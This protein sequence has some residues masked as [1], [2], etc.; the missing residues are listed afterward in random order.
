VDIVQLDNHSALL[1]TR[2]AGARRSA[3]IAGALFLLAVLVSV[4]GSL[5]KEDPGRSLVFPWVVT[6]ALGLGYL[7]AW[8]RLQIASASAELVEAL[9]RSASR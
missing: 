1:Q 5:L 7:M 4:A 6:L 8:V 3:A 2:I 9:R